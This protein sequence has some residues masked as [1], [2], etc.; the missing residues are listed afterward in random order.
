LKKKFIHWLPV[1]VYFVL[2]FV[3]S[4]FPIQVKAGTDKILHFIEYFLMGFLI[5][6]SLLLSW[7]LSRWQGILIAGLIGGFLGAV[8][9]IHQYFVPGR[10]ASVYDASVDFLGSFAGAIAFVYLGILLFQ[11]KKLYPTQNKCC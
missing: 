5:A 3:L 9:E 6:R 11:T 2:I 4:S 7:S 1:Y 10:F 8:D